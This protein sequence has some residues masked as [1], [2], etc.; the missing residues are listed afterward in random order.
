MN[1]GM[2]EKKTAMQSAGAVV[3]TKEQI[4]YIFLKRRYSRNRKKV[5]VAEA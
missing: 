2:N 3:Q 1:Q 5:S 4:M